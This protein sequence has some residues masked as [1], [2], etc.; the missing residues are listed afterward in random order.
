[1]TPDEQKQAIRDAFASLNI[2]L[3]SIQTEQLLAFY[4]MIVE[5]NKVMNLTSI[6]GF[7]DFVIKHYLDSL[8]FSDKVLARYP[9]KRIR[10]IDIGTGAGFPGVPMKI[11]YPELDTVLLDSLNKRL[12]FLNDAISDLNLQNIRTVHYRAEDGARDKGLREKFDLVVS[13]AVANMSTLSEYCIPYVKMNG[14]FTAYK[15]IASEEEL[16]KA[17]P[18][19]QLLGG[20]VEEVLTGKIPNTDI[21]REIILIKKVHSTPGKYPRKAGTPLKNPLS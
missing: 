8:I 12:P 9:S 15:S 11:V 10:M 6:T 2:S 1:M 13:R 16:E 7:S 14:Y 21:E 18:A 4:E 20:K 5:K 17:E 19:I 3:S